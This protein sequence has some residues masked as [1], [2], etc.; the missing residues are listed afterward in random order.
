LMEYYADLL[1]SYKQ[2]KSIE[3]PFFEE[4]KNSWKSLQRNIL[5]RWI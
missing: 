1:K 2:L 3:D 5:L 4:D